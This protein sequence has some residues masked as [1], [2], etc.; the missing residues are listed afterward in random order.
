MLLQAAV[1]SMSGSLYVCDLP[2]WWT[3][4]YQVLG[5]FEYMVVNKSQIYICH[6]YIIFAKFI[7]IHIQTVVLQASDAIFTE[8]QFYVYEMHISQHDITVFT[9]DDC[10]I[11]SLKTLLI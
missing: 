8:D 5:I 10:G 9:I 2:I 3:H 4:Q 7:K 6:I 1:V 11:A